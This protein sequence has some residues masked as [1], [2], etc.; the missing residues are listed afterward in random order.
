MGNYELMDTLVP[1]QQQMF[2]DSTATNLPISHAGVNANMGIAASN[3]VGT[4]QLNKYNS[5]NM[6][7][8]TLMQTQQSFNTENFGGS[9][10]QHQN[11]L[12]QALKQINGSKSFGK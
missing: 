6:C 1:C 4:V 3:V 9:A 11:N 5:Q 2:M 10:H 12:Q 8:T 7:A